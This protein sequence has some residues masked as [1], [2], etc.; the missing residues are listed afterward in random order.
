MS[1]PRSLLLILSPPHF[2]A[3][4]FATSSISSSYFSRGN[5]SILLVFL[6]SLLHPLVSFPAFRNGRTLLRRFFR[7]AGHFRP[8]GPF[9][10][11]MGLCKLNERDGRSVRLAKTDGGSES[12]LVSGS[13][14]E[15]GLQSRPRTVLHAYTYR[16][17]ANYYRGVNRVR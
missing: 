11:A 13:N 8:N 14:K 7:G 17:H 3:R 4:L 15:A 6:A 16:Q 5:S 9:S 12:R 1:Q 2:P 10:R